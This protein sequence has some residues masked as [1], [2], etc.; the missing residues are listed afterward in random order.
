M[1]YLDNAATTGVKPKSVILAVTSALNNMS[2][3]PSR[4][5][6]AK[7]IKASEMVFDCRKL[8]KDLFGAS[9]ENCVCFVGSCT[10]AINTVLYGNLKNGDHIIISSL[11]HNA[12]ARTVY[13]L[14]KDRGVQFSVADIDM[15]SDEKTVKNFTQKIRPNTKMIVTTAASNVVGIK[16]PLKRLGEICK[17]MNILFCVDAAQ[18]AGVS[19]IDV[20]EMNIDFLCI[21]AHKGL[22]AP[23]GIGVLIA[24][25]PIE[26]VL[27]T[28][29]TGV[30]SIDLIQPEELPERIESGT[31][32]LP[33]IAGLKAG[34]E[35]VKNK[36][37]E[38]IEKYEHSL[39]GYAFNK[40]SGIGSK[41]YGGVPDI[42]THAPVLSFNIGSYHSEE[43]GRY[44]DKNDIAVRCGLH[45][46]P[47]AHKSL[48]TLERGTVRISPSVFNS[49]QDIDK[50]IFALK[51]L[52]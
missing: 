11:E 43:I 7:S 30:N 19:R 9:S 1:V 25:K 4:G 21:A 3:N 26:N 47:M 52:I 24:E 42:R 6:Y 36:G 37:S 2:V 32:N 20:K 5:G 10:Q 35:F 46:S 48:G 39:C 17:S 8:L 50:L 23:M 38:N 14:Y 18:V 41:V 28:G 45:C 51:R 22:Y 16:I 31:L 29:G 13:R 40:L 44:L 12:V 33:G 34:V 15:E 49:K 27:I